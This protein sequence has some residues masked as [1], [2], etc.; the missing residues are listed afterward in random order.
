MKFL[1]VPAQGAKW[2]K[3]GALLQKLIDFMIIKNV[4]TIFEAQEILAAGGI[5]SVIKDKP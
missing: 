3:M 4:I 5:I 1:S 2:A